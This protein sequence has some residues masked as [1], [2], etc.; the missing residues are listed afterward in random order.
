M[1]PPVV[2][3]FIN[4]IHY[5]CKYHESQF[6]KV[7]I[8]ISNWISQL[9]IPAQ[10]QCHFLGPHFV[11]RFRS[12]APEPGVV[13]PQNKETTNHDSNPN[14]FHFLV[15]F[16]LKRLSSRYNQ[17]CFLYRVKTLMHFFID[18]IIVDWNPRPQHHL[19]AAFSDIESSNINQLNPSLRV[20]SLE[21][22][23]F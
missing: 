5:S 21:I 2:S 7:H 4:P 23:K 20:Q 6:L 10:H 8:I 16:E 19:A 3:W 12:F 1:C 14:P 13:R 17:L 15:G 18:L 11:F 22:S 9:P